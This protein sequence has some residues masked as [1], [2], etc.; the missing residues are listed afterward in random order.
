[1]GGYY[2]NGFDT[3]GTLLYGYVPSFGINYTIYNFSASSNYNTYAAFGQAEY[4]ILPDLM[5]I[6]G[7]AISSISTELGMLHGT[8]DGWTPLAT[9]R[10]KFTDGIL[11]LM[12][13]S[14][15][16]I[17]RAASMPMPARRHTRRT[18]P[19]TTNWARNTIRPTTASR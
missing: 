5:A 2:R 14:R 9:L 16:A 15:K 13:P 12:S 7:C 3:S 18:R 4:D 10:E 1:M 6:I 8:S 19:R 17:A 11:W